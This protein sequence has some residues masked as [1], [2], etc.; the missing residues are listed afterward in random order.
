[1]LAFV[2]PSARALFYFRNLNFDVAIKAIPT[3]NKLSLMGTGISW[4]PDNIK[5]ALLKQNIIPLI[6]LIKLNVFLSM[7]IKYFSSL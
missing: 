7:I 4:F 5:I 1:M 3:T 2:R 6:N